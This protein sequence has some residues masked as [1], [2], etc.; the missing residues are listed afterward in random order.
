LVVRAA[1]CDSAAVESPLSAVE[2]PVPVSSLPLPDPESL[3]DSVLTVISNEPAQL[4]G[5]SGAELE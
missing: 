3:V 1:Y 5:F 2:S 4:I